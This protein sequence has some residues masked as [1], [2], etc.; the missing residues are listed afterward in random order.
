MSALAMILTA[1][2]AV[3]GDGP[4]KVS[5]EIAEQQRLDLRGE[6]KGKLSKYDRKYGEIAAKV[7]LSGGR[8]KA[9]DNAKPDEFVADVPVSFIDEGDG[10]FRLRLDEDQL[11]LGIY[12]QEGDR[13]IACFGDKHRPNEFK[14]TERR[15]LIILHRAKSR[16]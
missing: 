12:R 15:G 9:E 10:K 8:L 1:A 16:K 5:G 13:L 11:Y 2:M 4:E 14:L 3:P 6:W 7:H